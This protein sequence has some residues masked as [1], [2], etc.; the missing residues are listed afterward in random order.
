[1]PIEP[2]TP[3]RPDES[4]AVTA[5]LAAQ[6]DEHAIPLERA[7]LEETVASALLDDGRALVLLARDG[8]H[9]VGVAYLSFQLT[10]EY[11]GR[12]VWLEEL[13]VVPERR[14]QGIG[15]RLLEAC[16][17]VARARGCRAVELEVEGSH[18][19]AANLYARAGFRALDRVHW[20]LPLG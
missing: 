11:G 16:L 2:P 6:L 8:E 12:V 20:A 13:Y 3:A 9:P 17:E 4:P 18:A 14:G 5:L 10:L 7:L 15:Q 19:R 1:M